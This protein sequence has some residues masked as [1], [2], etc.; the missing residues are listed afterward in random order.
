MSL[1]SSLPIG[2]YLRSV[3][4]PLQTSAHTLVAIF[5]S[6]CVTIFQRTL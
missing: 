2:L 1:Y 5:N 3:L 4:K 6:E